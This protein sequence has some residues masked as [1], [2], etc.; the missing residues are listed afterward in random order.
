MRDKAIEQQEWWQEHSKAILQ[1]ASA[2]MIGH[3][4]TGLEHEEETARRV[5]RMAERIVREI[6][7]R[8]EH[9]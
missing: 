3:R 4:G 6:C 8:C 2:M 1:V 9:L 5:V 7:R